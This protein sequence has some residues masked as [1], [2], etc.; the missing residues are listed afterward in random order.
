VSNDQKILV[1]AMGSYDE[2]FAAETVEA[3][4]PIQNLIFPTQA[5]WLQAL[6]GFVRQRPDLF[7][8][9]RVHPREFPNKR[10]AKK[11]EHATMLESLF[12]TLPSNVAINWPVDRISIYD[13]AEE[14]DVFLNSWSSVGKEMSV[15]GLP[16]VIYS[17]DLPLYPAELNYLGTSEED[18]FQ[19]I[20]QA[21]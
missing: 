18:Y 19:K 21:L 7:L 14:T 9:I 2:E 16:V 6:V 13:L 5:A 17:A 15:L 12:T 20:Q 4:R 11:S 10:E 8:I 3:K 1:A